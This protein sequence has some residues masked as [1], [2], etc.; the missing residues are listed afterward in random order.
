MFNASMYILFVSSYS[1]KFYT[2]IIVS[3]Q[4]NKLSDSVFW[5]QVNAL[6]KAND[7]NSEMEI[8]KVFYWLNNG[9]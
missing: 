5:D 7:I 9:R 1:L 2:M 4:R 8:F 3:I 6:E